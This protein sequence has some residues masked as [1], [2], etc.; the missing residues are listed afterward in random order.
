MTTDT[1]VR[2]GMLGAGFI[3]QM[4]SL[5]LRTAAYTRQRPSVRADLVVL[6]EADP[7]LGAEVAHRYQWQH[8]TNDWKDLTAYD[9]DLFVNAGPNHLH[10][11]ACAAAA[12]AGVGLFCEKPLAPTADEAFELWQT[13]RRYGVLNRCAFMHRFIPAIQLLRRMVREGDLGEV[14]NF[15]SSFLLNMAPR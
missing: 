13:A 11:V 2:V 3:G 5:A 7:D 12:E 15:R 4:H 8:T 10:Q 1:I 14:T 9:L 6:A